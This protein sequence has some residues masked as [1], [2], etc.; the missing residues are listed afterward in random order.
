MTPLI[1]TPRL[2]LRGPGYGDAR[3]LADYLGNFAVSGNLSRVPHPY[4]VDH[5]WDWLS[6]WRAD[7]VPAETQFVLELKGEGAVGVAGFHMENS[8]AAIGYWLG[9]PHWGQGLMSEALYAILDWYFDVT[10]SDIVLSGVFHFNMASAALQMKF[11]FVE[12]GRSSRH[13]LARGE[14][15]EHIDTELTREAYVLSRPKPK[16]IAAQ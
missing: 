9:E 12:T 3:R 15:V 8:A 10:N 13:C 14:E 4:T 16:G 6:R 5:A 11:G 7:A 1:E 2:R